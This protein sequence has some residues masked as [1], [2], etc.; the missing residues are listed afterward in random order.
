MLSPRTSGGQYLSRTWARDRAEAIEHPEAFTAA[1]L[2]RLE[3]PAGAIPTE[4]FLD[5]NG[6]DIRDRPEAR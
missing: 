4:Y 2:E 1:E 3:V 6:N 5:A